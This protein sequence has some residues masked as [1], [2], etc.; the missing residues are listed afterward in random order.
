MYSSSC[1]H[2]CNARLWQNIIGHTCLLLWTGSNQSTLLSVHSPS[3]VCTYSITATV[4]WLM[5]NSKCHPDGI[6][7]RVLLP[8]DLVTKFYFLVPQRIARYLCGPF[9]WD[10]TSCSC[11]QMPSC[12]LLQRIKPRR[13]PRGCLHGFE[14]PQK[15]D[16]TPY[17]AACNVFVHHLRIH[18]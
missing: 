16:S 3:F 5:E 2:V 14:S 11:E 18:V 6:I 10:F 12:V 1:R 7:S 15:L 17:S 9:P 4:Q 8:Y 13:C